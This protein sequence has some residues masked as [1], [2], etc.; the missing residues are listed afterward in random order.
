[1][2]YIPY[3]NNYLHLKGGEKLTIVQ[4]AMKDEFLRKQILVEWGFGRVNEKRVEKW[5]KKEFPFEYAELKRNTE[6]SNV[7]PIATDLTTAEERT[8][9]LN[10]V[11]AKIDGE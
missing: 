11:L 10:R 5:L 6:Q 2:L 3:I 4:Q 8:D 9:F 1:M 7:I